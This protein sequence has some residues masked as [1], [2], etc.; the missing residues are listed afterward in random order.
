MCIYMYVYIYIYTYIHIHIPNTYIYIYIYICLYLYLYVW[1]VKRRPRGLRP[2]LQDP[3][4]P[5]L[6]RLR[7]GDDEGDHRYV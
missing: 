7:E 6:G 1:Y 5:R 4:A 2:R 3:L